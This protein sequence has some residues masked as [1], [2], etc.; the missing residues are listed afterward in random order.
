MACEWQKATRSRDRS[1]QD[2]CWLPLFVLLRK[3]VD[4]CQALDKEVDDINVILLLD[5]RDWD[6]AKSNV[7]D[8]APESITFVLT[9]LLR[10]GWDVEYVTACEMDP[11]LDLREATRDPEAE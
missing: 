9:T 8:W 11:T 5:S 2:V 6:R 3:D 7:T 10:P 4:D 1:K